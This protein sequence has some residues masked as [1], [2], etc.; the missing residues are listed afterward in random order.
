MSGRSRSVGNKGVKVGEKI[1]DE[2][3]LDVEDLE[4][5]ISNLK[6][7]PELLTWEDFRDRYV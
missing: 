4:D 1:E 2:H 5:L 3:F 6:A 7:P